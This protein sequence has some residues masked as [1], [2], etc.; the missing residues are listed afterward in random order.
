MK[1]IS[2]RAG[3]LVVGLALS[4]GVTTYAVTPSELRD[5]MRELWADHGIWTHEWIVAELGDI[6]NAQLVAKRLLKNQDDIG[7]AI[8]PF[9]GQEAGKRLAQLLKDHIL[10]AVDLVVAAKSGDKAKLQ[11]ADSRWHKNARDIAQF[12]SSANPYWSVQD[13]VNMLNQHLKLTA[14]QATARLHKEWEKDIALYDKIRHQL[15]MMADALAAGITRQFPEK[16]QERK[17][18]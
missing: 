10:I 6:P 14:D 8:V 9:Y 15:Q 7:N 13:L 17:K 1:S 12:L 16:L 2:K 18:L 5:L 4:L 11:N 3:W